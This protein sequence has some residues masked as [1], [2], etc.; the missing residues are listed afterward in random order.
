MR[1][2]VVGATGLVGVELFNLVDSGYFPECDEIVPIASN[3]SIGKSI[4]CFGREWKCLPLET[5]SFEGVALA[6][7]SVGDSLSAEWIPKLLDAF[8]KI[9]IVDKSNAFRM[10]GRV[11]LVACGVNDNAITHTDRLVANPNC[12]T[13]QLALAVKPLANAFGIER[14]IASTYQSVSGAGRDGIEHLREEIDLFG[15]NYDLAELRSSGT[16][17]NVLP[18]IGSLD[19]SGFA[20][21]ETK[22]MVELAKILNITD[23]KI[24]ATACR[25]DVFVGHSI[26]IFVR[27]GKPVSFEEVEAHLRNGYGLDYFPNHPQVY[28]TPISASRPDYDLVQ[29]GRLRQ[30]N[31]DGTEYSLFC[32]A[33]NLR[34][35]AALN[36]IRIARRMLGFDAAIGDCATESV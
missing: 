24:T 29:V 18:Q 17:H 16:A 34:I 3:D 2:A 1:I 8:P 5:S 7:F 12:T 35:G 32:C 31:E 20:G 33:N 10:D 4:S 23:L 22:I 25:V 30:S 26:S 14:V 13:I 36:A 9:K 11:P 27:L 28:P 21:E 19:D 6:S 15:G